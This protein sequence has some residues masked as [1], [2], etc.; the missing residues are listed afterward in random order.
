M[1]QS[2][3]VRAPD[4][5]RFVFRIRPRDN[6]DRILRQFEDFRQSANQLPVCRSRNGWRRNSNSQRPV[7]LSDNLATR[8]A[9]NDAYRE[10]EAA[11]V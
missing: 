1:R 11:V 2:G 5:N 6:L 10:D 8:R 7:M 9:R 4:P 3:R